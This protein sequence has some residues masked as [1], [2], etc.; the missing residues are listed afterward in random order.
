MIW[1]MNKCF[2]FFTVSYIR[3]CYN[4]FQTHVLIY[5]LLVFLGPDFQAL[6]NP[7]FASTHTSHTRQTP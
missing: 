1:M 5:I 7:S 3:Q 4:T 6:A 2:S